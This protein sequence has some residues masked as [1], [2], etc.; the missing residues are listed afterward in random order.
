MANSSDVNTSPT[1]PVSSGG[2]SVFKKILKIGGMLF[3]LLLLVAAYLYFFQ[4]PHHNQSAP[5]A[6]I[7]PSGDKTIDAIRR[8]V[9]FLKVHQESDGEFSAGMLDPK[10]G[11]TS[12]VVDSIAR[13]PDKYRE[14]DQ[15]FLKKAAEA[16][17]KHQQP[18]GSI[19]TPSF[20]L[21]T[22]TTACS[23][24]ALTALENPAYAKNVE[25]ARDYLISIQYKDDEQ[26]PNFGSAGYKSDGKTSGD[27]TANWI[28]ALKAA[29]VKEGDPAFKNAEKFLSRLQNNEETNPTKGADYEV[30]NDGGFVYRPGESKAPDEKGKNGKRIPKSYGLMSYAGLKSFMYMDIKKD[31]PRVVAAR[32]WVTDNFTLEENRNIGAD[33]LFYYFLTM[34][35]ALTLYGD[36]EITTS[37]GKVHNW[38]QELSDKL[39]SMQ[40]TDGSWH[41]KASNRWYENDSVQVTAFAIRT[42]SICHDFLK[43]TGKVSTTEPKP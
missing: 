14:T 43:K 37:D 4:L 28:E 23:I 41:N 2:T 24:L 29:G 32:K 17:L 33:G 19:A 22:Y 5:P 15:P 30:G 39:I 42:M 7:K 35:K 27:V 36:V 20:G 9:E 38:A 1:P 18:N 21:D 10:P 16:I 12:L 34:A 11:F 13:S 3:V 26:N 8:G 31:D 6:A 25:K 40:D